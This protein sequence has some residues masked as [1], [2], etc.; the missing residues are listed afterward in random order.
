M[1]ISHKYKFIF[2]KTRKTA[3]TSLELFLS[4]LC[5]QKDIV[6][7]LQERKNF[8][9]NYEGFFNPIPEVTKYANIVLPK[10][11]HYRLYSSNPIKDCL[12]KRKFYNHIP[13]YQ[14]KERVSE[15]IW[16]NYYK[17]CFDRN[18]W[19][20]TI[21]HY[22]FCYGESSKKLSFEEYI[23][24][25]ILSWNYPLYTDPRCPND[26]IVDYVGKYENLLEELTVIFKKINIPFDKNLGL[27]IQALGNFRKDNRPYQEFLS[28]QNCDLIKKEFFQEI[29][30]HGYTFN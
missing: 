24:R 15:D 12:R 25:N 5:A 4:K 2:I 14:V 3:G 28:N 13:A 16:K 21:S 30:L 8:P 29:K 7:P 9:R 11:Y 18:P 19:D 22:F 6:T 20:K 26:I 1:I 23:T 27:G 17:F 10:N